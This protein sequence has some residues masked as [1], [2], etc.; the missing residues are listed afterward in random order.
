MRTA[1]EVI[2]PDGRVI[3]TRVLAHPHVDEQPFT[4]SLAAVADSRRVPWVRLRGHDLVHGYGGRG[5]GE[6]AARRSMTAV[7]GGLQQA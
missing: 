6:R 1:G 3:A 5:D 2:A 4:R 7:P